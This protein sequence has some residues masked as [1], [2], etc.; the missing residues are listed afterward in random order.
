MSK[1]QK[2]TKAKRETWLD[3]VYPGVWQSLEKYNNLNER[4]AVIVGAASLDLALEHLIAERFI[5]KGKEAEEFLGVDDNGRAPCG[6]FSSRIQLALLLGIIV[7][8]DA[9]LLRSIKLLRNTFAHTVKYSLE[10]PQ[11]EVFMQSFR[12]V[13]A[14]RNNVVRPHQ[15]WPQ[16]FSTPKPSEM[17]R[18][19]Y[20]TSTL[21]LFEAYF[22][23][24]SQKIQSV[25]SID[26]LFDIM[27]S[28]PWMD[29]TMVQRCDTDYEID[30]ANPLIKKPQSS[31]EMERV[32]KYVARNVRIKKP[33]DS[34]MS[35]PPTLLLLEGVRTP[36]AQEWAEFF[37]PHEASTPRFSARD[38]ISVRELFGEVEYEQRLLRAKEQE[39]VISS[40]EK[41]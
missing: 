38:F 25:T 21:I 23:G 34:N 20:I 8:V 26:V 18:L 24:L 9:A 32:F 1:K 15:P 28:A 36:H 33:T 31:I 6:T 22:Y 30:R 35:Q 17:S 5:L 14:N 40:E 13:V 3:D 29:D 27:R 2:R 39:S 7:P 19:R 37:S 41:S 11:G 10:S 4:E 16:L 12:D